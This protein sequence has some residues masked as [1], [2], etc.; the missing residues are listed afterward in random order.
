MAATAAVQCEGGVVHSAPEAARYEG[1]GSIVGDL[2][3]LVSL[4]GIES[5][6]HARSVE[7][8]NNPVLAGYFGLLPELSKVQEP[9]VVEANRGLSKRDIEAVVGRVAVQAQQ[10]TANV[11]GAQGERL[12]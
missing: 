5:V 10:V 12:N 7:I 3:K 2:R 9:L 8:R 4:A 11:D 1:C 6:E